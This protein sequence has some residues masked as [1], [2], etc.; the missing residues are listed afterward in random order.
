VF[1]ESTCYSFDLFRHFCCRKYRL[2]TMHSVR[3]RQMD[4]RQY[5]A[6]SRSQAIARSSTIG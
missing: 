5:H 3:D 4:R 2:A 6:N 1:L